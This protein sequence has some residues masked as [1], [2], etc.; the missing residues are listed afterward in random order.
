MVPSLKRHM[1]QGHDALVKAMIAAAPP[2]IKKAVLEIL[3]KPKVAPSNAGAPT[4]RRNQQQRQSCT[5]R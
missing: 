5:L 1:E 4:S 2:D 3:R